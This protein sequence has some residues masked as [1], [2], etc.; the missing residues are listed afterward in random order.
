MIS[1]RSAPR[2]SPRLGRGVHARRAARLR[3]R[4]DETPGRASCRARSGSRSTSHTSCP[5]RPKQP[6]EEAP[7]RPWAD[8]R[9]LH[10]ICF[11][12]APDPAQRGFSHSSARPAARRC[13]R[14]GSPP[15]PASPARRPPCPGSPTPPPGRGGCARRR[16][17]R[18]GSSRPGST[19]C[20]RDGDGDADLAQTAG[21]ARVRA[22]QAWRRP[23]T[24]ARGCRR[25]PG[26]RRR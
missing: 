9:D 19:T 12:V 22:D 13:R 2:A 23:G 26:W 1:A 11:P 24:P 16:R 20:A 4:S 18:P 7:E 10:A 8:D 15:A 14:A 25:C 21:L 6:G 5:A 3:R 17:H